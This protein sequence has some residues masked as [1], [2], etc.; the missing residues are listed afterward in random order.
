RPCGSTLVPTTPAEWALG[1]G[2]VLGDAVIAVTFRPTWRASI[3][4]WATH[5][6]VAV[7]ASAIRWMPRPARISRTGVLSNAEYRGL[8]TNK[9]PRTRPHEHVMRTGSDLAHRF[10]RRPRKR[11]LH[12]PV[13][14]LRPAPARAVR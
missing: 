10:T 2:G 14:P 8:T 9:S 1:S 6:S 13:T 7:P 5:L 12:H 11:P 3:A 4:V